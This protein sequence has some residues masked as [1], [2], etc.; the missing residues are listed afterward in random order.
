MNL[1]ISWAAEDSPV[2]F[3]KFSSKK[4]AIEG[5]FEIGQPISPV[6]G[7]KGHSHGI[8]TQLMLFERQL[9]MQPLTQHQFKDTYLT[10]VEN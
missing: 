9:W 3:S 1:G 2:V 5:D 6:E 7:V 4:A 10:V 8:G